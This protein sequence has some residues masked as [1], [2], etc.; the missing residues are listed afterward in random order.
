MER[1]REREREKFRR[2]TSPILIIIECTYYFKGQQAPIY[3]ARKRGLS[4]CQQNDRSN[5]ALQQDLYKKGN[6][7]ILTNEQYAGLMGPIT[8]ITTIITISWA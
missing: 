3:R 1:E 5:R 4:F 8:P 7:T 2:E 6:I